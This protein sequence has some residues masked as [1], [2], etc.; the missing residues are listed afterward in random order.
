MGGKLK[1]VIEDY[2]T[3]CYKRRGCSSE[4]K[5]ERSKW[6]NLFYN[7]VFSIEGDVLKVEAPGITV[8]A[9]RNPTPEV[10]RPA[11]KYVSKCYKNWTR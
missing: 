10:L 7:S 2:N 8:A 3:V 6:R 5:E 1:I 11:T 9:G 4:T